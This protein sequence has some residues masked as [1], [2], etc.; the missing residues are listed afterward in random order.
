[1]VPPEPTPLR[2]YLADDIR[3]AADTLVEEWMDWIVERASV[4]PARMLPR[5]AIRDHIPGVIQA[6]GEALRTPLEATGVDDALRSHA[7]IRHDQG[8]DIE[9][10]FKEYRCLNQIVSHRMLDALA[11]YPGEADP[12]EVARA[13]VRLSQGLAIV[14]ERTVGVYRR[15]AVEQKRELHVQ[16]EDYVRTITH[17]LKQPL[18]A[19]TAGAGML[20][21]GGAASGVTRG[22]HY[23]RI[24]RN[25][26]ERAVKLID[27]IRT[28]A[29]V[30]GAQQG[31]EWKPLD[32]SVDLVLRDMGDQARAKEVR[33][34]VEN[35]LPQIDV[36]STRVE[37]AL[38][39]LISNAIKYSDPSKT[40]RWARIEVVRVDPEPAHQWAVRVSDNGLGIPEAL[41]A[42]IFERHFRAHP[43]MGEGTGLGLAITRQVIEQAGGRVRFESEEGEGSM[44][45]FTIVGH[46]SVAKLAASDAEG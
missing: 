27:D 12:Q 16:L 30:E 45:E 43:E 19:I 22:E 42:Q 9:E 3:D 4:R 5:E 2:D 36:D 38:V 32:Y 23:L 24:I 26:I 8:Y 46:A 7:R 6:I 1:M 17:E 11:R 28:L 40:D 37:I 14:T 13:F 29:L 20:E 35:P 21:E 39:N 31:E 41:Q 25:G 10:L 34:E 18:N 33:L 44:F 15:I